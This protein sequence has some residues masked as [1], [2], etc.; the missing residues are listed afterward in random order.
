MNRRRFL[1]TTAVATALLASPPVLRGAGTPRRL[2]AGFLGGAHS[3]A[4]EKWRL[5]R[6]STDY[7]LRGMSEE[8]ASVRAS[9]ERLGAKFLS[10]EALLA[11]CEVVFVESAVADHG[12][13]AL[14]ALRAGKHVHVEKPPADNLREVEEMVRWARERR[15]ALQ[16]G[17]MWRYHP[18]FAAIF[19]AV[20]QGWLGEVYLAR[21]MIAN[22]LGADRRPEWAQFAGGG[23][24]EL[25]SHLVDALL[26]LLGEPR[27]VTPFLRKHGDFADDLKDNNVAVFEFPKATGLVLNSTLQP[28]AGPQRVFEVFGTNGR[29]TLRPI[30]PP[31][32]EIELARAAGPYKSGLHPVPFAKYDR[33]VA[34]LADLAAVIRGE[35]QLPVTLEEELRVQ[36]WLLKASGMDQGRP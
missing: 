25:G 15:L 3:H 36:K 4:A 20:R 14:M 28:N 27:S 35:R 8:S 32:L 18:G 24:F 11:E 13:H 23:F 7:E 16:V 6:A 10:P 26:R 31:A 1:S 22:Q 33:Y 29:A 34:D 19:E 30:E 21:G 12:R 5:V 9:Y 17:Y 2:K